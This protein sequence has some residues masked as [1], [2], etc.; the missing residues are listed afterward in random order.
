MTKMKK[1]NSEPM[2]PRRI[3]MS[4]TWRGERLCF[5]FHGATREEVAEAL[6]GMRNLYGNCRVT[7][8]RT[9]RLRN[10][11]CHDTVVATISEPHLDMLL[12]KEWP[13][14]IAQFIVKM[15]PCQD[16][17]PQVMYFEN[18]DRFLNT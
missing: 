17:T 13:M 14:L 3:A 8:E 15:M 18:F 5:A 6:Q 9:S 7:V 4:K 1:K 12:E 10:G 11:K 2:L 16:N